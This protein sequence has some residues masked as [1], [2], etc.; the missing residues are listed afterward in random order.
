LNKVINGWT[1][2]TCI[3]Y[4]TGEWE[5]GIKPKNGNWIIVQQYNSKEEA[6][7][8]HKEYINKIKKGETN[9]KDIDIW[10]LNEEE[11]EGNEECQEVENI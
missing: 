3:G 7:K 9:F 11:D 4:D 10:G 8:G 2:D 1:V 5:T 6:I